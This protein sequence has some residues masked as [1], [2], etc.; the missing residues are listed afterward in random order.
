MS[1]LCCRKKCRAIAKAMQL[2]MEKKF[3]IE[4]KF[5]AEEY[6]NEAFKKDR[7][8]NKFERLNYDEN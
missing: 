2:F 8:F 3:K 6:N 7:R 5:D 4:N 1:W